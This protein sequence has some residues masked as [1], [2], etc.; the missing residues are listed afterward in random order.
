MKKNYGVIKTS[1]NRGDI[2]IIDRDV[3]I[4]TPSKHDDSNKKA[5]LFE[6]IL[7]EQ[8]EFKDLQ[9]N[10]DTYKDNSRGFTND[11]STHNMLPLSPSLS[12]NKELSSADI[13]H[14]VQSDTNLNASIIRN[15]TQNIK[16]QSIN[17]THVSR[18]IDHQKLK[19]RKLKVFTVSRT[20]FQHSSQMKL[21]S[22]A[23][24]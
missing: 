24:P 8:E 6:Q 7:Q 20:K 18:Q 5:N 12:P 22:D 1:S 10:I 3:L 2:K 11:H 17:N 14:I 9:S 15:K 23:Q 16:V 19:S 13:M 4:S 21:S